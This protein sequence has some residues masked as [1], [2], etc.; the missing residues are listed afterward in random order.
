MF[1]TEK[2][3]ELKMETSFL[4]NMS[5]ASLPASHP[6]RPDFHPASLSIPST[7]HTLSLIYK[8]WCVIMTLLHLN[9]WGAGGSNKGCWCCS[10]GKDVNVECLVVLWLSANI[11]WVCVCVCVFMSLETPA[12][13]LMESKW[14][15][16]MVQANADPHWLFSPRIMMVL[17]NW[18]P[19]ASLGVKQIVFSSLLLNAGSPFSVHYTSMLKPN[20]CVWNA[21]PLCSKAIISWAG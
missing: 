14:L 11:W 7:T 10:W 20:E 8:C 9:Y 18:G 3:S 6:I 15:C 17:M 4:I 13:R 21:A 2:V 5:G 12:G 19:E 16:L 1:S